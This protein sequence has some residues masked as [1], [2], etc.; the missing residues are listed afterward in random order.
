MLEFCVAAV[1]YLV[2][3]DFAEAYVSLRSE[4]MTYSMYVRC[5]E[6]TMHIYIFSWYDIRELNKRPLHLSRSPS[7]RIGGTF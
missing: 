2:A 3:Q 5:T 1:L 7:L 4:N 6:S